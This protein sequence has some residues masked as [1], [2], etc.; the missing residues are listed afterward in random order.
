MFASFDRCIF[1][2]HE[3]PP[4][5]ERREEEGEC[6]VVEILAVKGS[7]QCPMKK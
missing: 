5:D 3:L 1:C 4:P 6:G 2:G 7:S